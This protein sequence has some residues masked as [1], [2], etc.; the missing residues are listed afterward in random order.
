MTKR[1]QVTKQLGVFWAL[2]RRHLLVFMKN[3]PTVIFTLM[4]PIVIL[5]VYALFLRNMEVSAIKSSLIQEGIRV[6]EDTEEGMLFLHRVY[7]VADCWMISGVLAVSCITVSLNTNYI[8]VRD[9]ESGIG[10]DLISSPIDR[11]L[12]VLSYFAFNVIVTFFINFIVYLICLIYLAAYGAYMISLSD[13]FAIIGVLLLSTMSASEITYFICS[14]IQTE[15]VLSPVVAVFSAAVGFLIGAYLPAN[16][17]PKSIGY[18]TS[19]FPGTYSA[20]LLR[21][22]FMKNPIHLLMTETPELVGHEKFV[23][24]LKEEFSLD[25]HFFG[26]NVPVDIMAYVLVIFIAIFTV[27]NLMFATKN[28]LRVPKS[29]RKK[30]NMV[31][32]ETEESTSTEST[33]S[34]E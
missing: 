33:I 26:K 29:K 8:V 1:N 15:S 3:V 14:F 30:K 20:G 21:N 25:I 24:S 16:M 28:F 9:K 2:T 6:N 23:N 4:V 12:I 32:G 10:K 5:I 17:I 19:F 18:V 34:Q 31:K 11:K 27:L 22:Y 13:F 7:G